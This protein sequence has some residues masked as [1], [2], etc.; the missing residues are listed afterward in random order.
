ML[1]ERAIEDLPFASLCTPIFFI[2]CCTYARFGNGN[3]LLHNKIHVLKTGLFWLF[4]KDIIYLFER[5][6]ASRGRDRGRGRS[7]L[8]TEQGALLMT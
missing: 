7:R 5:E 8:S 1:I 4:K 3:N 6:R 2:G